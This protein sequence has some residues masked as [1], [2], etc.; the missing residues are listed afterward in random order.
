M[1][2]PKQKP[3]PEPITDEPQPASKSRIAWAKLL[4][5]VFNIDVEIC[6]DCGGRAKVIAT[7]EEPEVIKKIL[8]HLGLPTKPPP[9]RPAQARGPPAGNFD[10]AAEQTQQV[11]PDE[12]Y[13]QL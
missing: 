10:P 2:I 7:I 6:S 5:R 9:I 13:S 1:I 4:K 3:I 8:T 12:D 11:F